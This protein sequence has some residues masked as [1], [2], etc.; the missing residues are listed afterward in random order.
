MVHDKNK[1]WSS[2]WL[3]ELGVKLGTALGMWR[4]IRETLLGE[5]CLIEDNVFEPCTMVDEVC[6]STAEHFHITLV[7]FSH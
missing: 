4:Q 6:S 5:V 1:H 3:L 7:K 2:L